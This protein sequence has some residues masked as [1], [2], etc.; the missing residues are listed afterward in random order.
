MQLGW[1]IRRVVTAVMVTMTAWAMP[2]LAAPSMAAAETVP[3]P[4]NAAASQAYGL[5]ASAC[6]SA[7]NCAAGGSYTDSGMTQQGLLLSEANGSWIASE[8]AFKGGWGIP[9]ASDPHVTSV[10]CASAGDCVAVGYYYSGATNVP[11]GFLV[12]SG[13]G[14][15]GQ[16]IDATGSSPSYL[17]F[18]PELLPAVSCVQGG[19]CYAIFNAFTGSAYENLVYAN[20]NGTWTAT[21]VTT[22]SGGSQVELSSIS[23]PANGPCAIVGN[24]QNAAGVEGLMATT[25]SLSVTTLDT[26]S[27]PNAASNPNVTPE[28][29]SCASAGNCTGV[30]YYE[31]LSGDYQGLVLSSTGGSWSRAQEITLPANAYG[32]DADLFLYDVSCA[33]AGNCEAVG[34]YDSSSTDTIDGL[35]LGESGGQW[36]PASEVGLP[37][38]ASSSQPGVYTPAVACPL[39]AG[40]LA[41]GVYQ[42]AS[43]NTQG[44]LSSQSA[45]GWSPTMLALPSGAT[46]PLDDSDPTSLSCASSGYCVLAGS[47]HEGSSGGAVLLEAPGSTGTP[48]ATAGADHA[49]VTWAAPADDGGLPVTGYRIVAND[50]TNP[51]HGGQVLSLG[52]SSAAVTL[53]TLTVGD[54]Y[55]FSVSAV[56]QL[57]IGLSQNS[58]AVTI[59]PTASQLSK[60]LTGLLSPSGPKRTLRA[61][62]AASGYTFS[63]HSLEAGRVTLDWYSRYATGHGRQRM[64]HRALIATAAKK[65][66]AGLTTIAVRLT[67]TGKRL[68]KTSVRLQVTSELTFV[69]SGQKPIRKSRTFTLS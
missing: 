54:N 15:W 49:S 26:S 31:D 38:T 14:S 5:V 65:L 57:G 9:S 66:P 40:C 19:D 58:E 7:G 44:F 20:T 46:D 41:A 56:N 52:T 55:T 42:D 35:F 50:L 62:R 17:V 18:S 6:P 51:S 29:V 21:H 32:Q 3:L 27:L 28:A 30:G 36:G 25:G 22:P 11:E 59:L 4:G 64:L 67:A 61:I 45:A 2:A 10:A 13:N 8:L 48:T 47:Y 63:F 33:S 68:L 1:S 39:A 53:P 23:C 34:S 24:Y 60:A 69:V 16:A 43:D 12:S 37:G